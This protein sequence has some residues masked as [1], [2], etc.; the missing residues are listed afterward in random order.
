MC[1]DVRMCASVC[2]IKS[3]CTYVKEREVIV[4]CVCVIKCVK[5]LS[6]CDCVCVLMCVS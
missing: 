3:V 2:L 5:R 6:M 1:K 4:V